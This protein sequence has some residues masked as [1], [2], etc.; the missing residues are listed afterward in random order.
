MIKNNYKFTYT[1]YVAF[2]SDIQSKYLKEICPPKYFSFN[3]FIKNT[4]IGTSTMIIKKNIIGNSKFSNTKICEDYY[5]KCEILKKTNYAH[6][7]QETLTKYRVRK[8]S[9]QSSKIRNLYW[10]WYINKKLNQLNFFNNL[11]SLLCISYN[12]LKKYGFK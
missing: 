5:F 6:C 7:L 12:S 10:I 8:N 9:L 3:K 11:I 4:S 2:K 1:N